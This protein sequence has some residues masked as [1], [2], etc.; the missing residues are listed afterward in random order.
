M[1]DILIKLEPRKCSLF[2]SYLHV[3]IDYWWGWGG[4]ERELL[5]GKGH[6]FLIV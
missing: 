4:E 1:I 6:G 5:L 2:Y 3:S